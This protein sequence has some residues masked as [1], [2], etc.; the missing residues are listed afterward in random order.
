MIKLVNIC[1]DYYIKDSKIAALKNVSLTLQDK[2]L[3][4]VSGRSGC[5]KTTLLNVMS[6]L[7]IPSSGEV[8][9]NYNSKN[10]YSMIFQDFQLIDYLNVYQN[11]KLVCDL[12]SNY[13]N[14]DK[15]IEKYGLKDIINHMPNEISGGQ[16]QRVAIVRAILMDK[17]VIFCDE[18]TGNLDIENAM[19]VANM[20]KEESKRRLVVV[21]S[22]DND[23]FMN[24]ADRIINLRDGSI[25]SDSD[26]ISNE[27]ISFNVREPELG[28]KT[29]FWLESLII[30]KNLLKFIFLSLSLLL[31]FLLLISSFNLFYNKNYVVVNN[32]YSKEG[33]ETVDFSLFESN[34]W[35]YYNLS[36]EK[37]METVDKYHC[38]TYYYDI[39]YRPYE[40]II[41]KRL[42]VSKKPVIDLL[43]GTLE[44]DDD[45]IIISDYNANRLSNDMA[46]V[47]GSKIGNLTVTGIF[48]TNYE[49]MD[50]SKEDYYEY[51]NRYSYASYFSEA[52]FKKLFKDE[53]FAYLNTNNNKSVAIIKD[54]V[55]DK[56]GLSEGEVVISKNIAMLYADD[57]NSLIG[58]NID[59]DFINSLD[60][61][62]KSLIENVNL[63]FIVKGIT[64]SVDEIY[65]RSNDFYEYAYLISINLYSY[66]HNGITLD[67]YNAKMIKSL[68]NSGFKDDMVI[69]YVIEEGYDYVYNISLIAIV[70]G[71]IVLIISVILT[72]NF[73][74]TLFEKEK[75][76]QGVL[77]SFGVSKKK[78]CV[79]Y[80]ESIIYQTLVSYIAA[81]ILNVFVIFALNKMIKSLLDIS[82]SIVYYNLSSLLC[83]IIPMAIVL[84][85]SFIV[86]LGKM[87]KKSIIDIIYER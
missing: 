84:I 36:N 4:F 47:I 9:N 31:S 59:F 15:L 71:I 6:G 43:Y 58:Q 18:P 17:P 14:L 11:L 5:G 64:D 2:G 28:V 55:E 76:I 34:G 40:N 86:I 8:S 62:N 39:E 35:Y 49:N 38:S 1:K 46:S 37:L 45:S 65:M 78:I 77:A 51:M 3:I 53:I 79:M 74:H 85:L 57:P 73:I 7:D 82:A 50:S 25:V 61:R 33:Y 42:Y 52:S 21:V 23:V 24:L 41:L 48:D 44:L 87:K 29:R 30:K 32:V 72:I 83:S 56:F 19:I 12:Y 75:R 10:F 22:H 63:N 16:K 69:S 26:S 80:Y 13:D 60:S 54:D 70:I 81:S 66:S 67:K 20:L 27:E 68:M